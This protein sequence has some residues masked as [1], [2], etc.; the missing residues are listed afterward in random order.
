MPTNERDCF[1]VQVLHPEDEHA[2]EQQVVGGLRVTVESAT[3]LKAADSNGLSDPY[4]TLV[5]Q[6]KRYRTRTIKKTLSP[7]WHQS[8]VWPGS[9]DEML[10][11]SLKIEL[12]DWNLLGGPDYL[13]EADVPLA[14]LGQHAAA[15]HRRTIS[16]STQGTVQVSHAAISLQSR[17]HAILAAVSLDLVGSPPDLPALV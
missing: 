12:S 8:F 9:R 16:L 6:G 3:G 7:E 14:F 15:V 2:W 13:G 4:A 11:A 5:C 1:R 17:N 10:H